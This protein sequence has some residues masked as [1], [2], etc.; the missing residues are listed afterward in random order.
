M[1]KLLEVCGDS[2]CWNAG[3]QGGVTDCVL[4]HLFREFRVT[5]PHK[6]NAAQID[7][8]AQLLGESFER[9]ADQ[10]RLRRKRNG[11]GELRFDEDDIAGQLVD[12]ALQ[13]QRHR[14]VRDGT[15]RQGYERVSGAT[16]VRCTSGDD[17][18]LTCEAV[19]EQRNHVQ[20]RFNGGRRRRDHLAVLG[21]QR[22]QEPCKV[23]DV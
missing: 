9:H 21:Q 3:P 5:A 18:R 20:F 15:L 7:A 1:R 11:F 19:A 16:L 22:W 6:H 10:Q 13:N 8:S 4:I 12:A 2:F 14:F 23:L 17:D